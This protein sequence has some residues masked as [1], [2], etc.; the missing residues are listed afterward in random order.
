[1]TDTTYTEGQVIRLRRCDHYETDQCAACGHEFGYDN[2]RLVRNGVL[3]HNFNCT[4]PL[5][6]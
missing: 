4:S 3:V 6:W 2:E 1:M 5:S